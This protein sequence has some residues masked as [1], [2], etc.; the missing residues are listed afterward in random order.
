MT[1]DEAIT[2]VISTSPIWIN[3]STEV[4][5]ETIFQMRK[6]LPTAMIVVLMD[7][8]H[9]ED[10][11]LTER[12]TEFKANVRKKDYGPCQFIEF[13]EWHHQSGMLRVMLEQEIV[14][15]PLVF[16]MEHDTP[17]KNDPLPWQGI[18]DAELSGEIACIRFHLTGDI[19]GLRGWF[20][21]K[22][23]NVP[24]DRV[25]CHTAWPQI[26]RL[27]YLQALVNTF[28][29]AKTYFDDGARDAFLGTNYD[30]FV[31][32]VYAPH[33]DPIRVYHTNGRCTRVSQHDTQ[34]KPYIQ[35]EDGRQYYWGNIV[36]RPFPMP[37]PKP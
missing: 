12:Y 20:L 31:S 33:G 37:K 22:N 14:K 15:T 35:H 24:L 27:D 2:A 17:L 11:A 9:P 34:G 25:I 10:P 19:K 5:D 6:H 7:G 29:G 23:G 28:G 1:P 13:E 4:L 21:S 32:C 30:R 3:P 8:V 16:W 18:V 36:Y 26:V